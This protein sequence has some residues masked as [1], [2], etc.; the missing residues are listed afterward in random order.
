M[1]VGRLAGNNIGPLLGQ[2]RTAK[3]WDCSSGSARLAAAGG[4][5]SNGR[6]SPVTHRLH[7]ECLAHDGAP[8]G[9]DLQV[10][11]RAPRSTGGG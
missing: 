2:I 10:R 11:H 3:V 9:N 7:G 5:G 4:A 1:E 8:A 6:S